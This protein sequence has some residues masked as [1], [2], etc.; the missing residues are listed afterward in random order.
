MALTKS[1]EKYGATFANA[2]HRVSELRYHVSEYITYNMVQQA[3]DENGDPVPPITEEVWATD[4]Q[5]FFTLLTYVDQDARDNHSEAVAR[6]E[7]SF[8][9]DWDATDNV[10]AQAYAYLKTLDIFADAVDA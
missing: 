7:Y 9:P 5:V 8:T 6:A 3:P 4:R 2:Y 1:F 10:L